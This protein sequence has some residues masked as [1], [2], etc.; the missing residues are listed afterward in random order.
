MS[1]EHEMYGRMPVGRLFVKCAVPGMVSGLVWAL[2]SIVDGIFVGN[3]LGS[4]ALA[5]VNLAWPVMTV[6]MALVDMIA[7]GSSVRVSMHLGNGDV[8]SA[9]RV[10]SGSV[11]L[12]V[13]ISVLF[14]LFGVL[15][16]GPLVRS[17]G[18]EGELAGMTAQYIAVFSLFA[19]VGLLFFATDNYLR[20]CGA[21]GLSMWINLGVTVLNILLLA[22]TIGAMGLGVWASAMATGL[23]VCAGSIVSLIPFLR[24]RLVLR[25]VHGWMDL[26]TTFRVMYN[27]I[28]TF[29]NSVSGSL[30]MIIANA[31][32]LS[33]VGNAGVSAFGI[34]MYVNSVIQALFTGMSAAIQPAISYNHGSGDGS[35]VRALAVVM[36]LSS[37][38]M[39]MAMAAICILADDELVSVFLGDGDAS[40]AA[41]A[42]SGLAVY[43]LTY[44][45]A[46]A[47]LNAN[48]ILAA[49]DL[50]AHALIV[51]V[52]SQLVLPALLLIPMSSMGVDGVWWSMVVA[53]IASAMLSALML[54]LGARRGIFRPGPV[55]DDP[56]SSDAVRPRA[57]IT[58]GDWMPV[59]RG[60]SNVGSTVR[61]GE[62]TPPRE[63]GDRPRP[64]RGGS[65]I[66]LHLSRDPL[67]RDREPPG[68]I[69]RRCGHVLRV[70][71]QR[72]D[73]N[74]GLG[75]RR[76]RR[77]SLFR[78]HEAR[79][80]QRCR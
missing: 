67:L 10:F 46:W 77:G 51:G 49:T 35:R 5:A 58:I 19:P 48:Q 45:L 75:G 36:S 55:R 38:F 44:L 63:R 25:F 37:V 32:L 29:F 20:I 2:C 59:H 71:R 34:I 54:A 33:I 61:R 4:D 80:P 28:S 43:G 13:V 17:F 30:F 64:L 69:V 9:R 23:S 50:P 39:G 8:E 74:G 79:G 73:R 76:L 66:R 27:G 6:V 70:L 60:F 72:E 68:G 14:L 12:I 16:S 78:V 56:G 15:L 7:A 41:M 22:V 3:F 21:V 53:S 1:S 47:A 65:R 26:R 52:S 31:V 24:G 18:A 40:V 11:R 42:S 57:P 62:E